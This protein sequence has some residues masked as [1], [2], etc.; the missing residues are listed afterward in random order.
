MTA[1]VHPIR[2]TP[3]SAAQIAEMLSVYEGQRSKICN[4]SSADYRQR[5]DELTA[6][7][8]DE[9]CTALS[10]QGNLLKTPVRAA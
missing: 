4:T 3:P 6:M 10:Q 8:D 1:T 9:L 7:T 5:K 2:D